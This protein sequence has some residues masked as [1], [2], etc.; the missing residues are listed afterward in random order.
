MRMLMCNIDNDIK[1]ISG[2]VPLWY[3]L[4]SS[5][6]SVDR[7]QVVWNARLAR[8]L[9]YTFTMIKCGLW[10]YILDEI[11]I[12]VNRSAPAIAKLTK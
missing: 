12:E 5:T 4:K 8:G 1:Q 9:P 7:G 10:I 11:A 3:D 2:S 6:I